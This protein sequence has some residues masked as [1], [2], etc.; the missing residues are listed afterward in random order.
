MEHLM[1]PSLRIVFAAVILALLGSFSLTAA[2]ADT[3]TKIV[4]AANGEVGQ[5]ETPPGSNCNPYGTCNAW[6]AHF[7]TWTW[8]EAG[9]DIPNTPSPATSTPGVSARAARTPATPG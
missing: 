3:R 1:R 8:R 2:A 5:G 9:I 4:N 6:C 7:A